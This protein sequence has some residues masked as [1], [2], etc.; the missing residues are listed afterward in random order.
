MTG[1]EGRYILGMGVVEGLLR[2]SLALLNTLGA[3]S[4]QTQAKTLVRLP[5]LK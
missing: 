4:D 3:V 5:L 1:G 2:S